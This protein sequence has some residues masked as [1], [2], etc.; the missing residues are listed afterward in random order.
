[1]TE[2]IYKSNAVVQ[3]FR[4][5]CRNT[6]LKKQMV[7]YIPNIT[8]AINVVRRAIQKYQEQPLTN[9]QGENNM[10]NIITEDMLPEFMVDEFVRDY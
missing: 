8:F 10:S 7:F 6:E 9:N 5:T 2:Q 1:M 3:E 4:Q